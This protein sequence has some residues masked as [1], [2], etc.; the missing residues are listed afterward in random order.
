MLVLVA[1]ILM[2]I[3]GWGF[4]AVRDAVAR[5]LPPGLRDTPRSHIFVDRYIWSAA[6]PRALRRRFILTQACGVAACACLTAVVWQ[7]HG[8][9]PAALFGAIT[10]C[11]AG[12]YA[13]R[14]HRHGV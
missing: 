11:G 13:F 9:Y 8:L 2:G 6:A 10:L 4:Y 3:A 14:A 7:V 12:Y 1:V 5:T